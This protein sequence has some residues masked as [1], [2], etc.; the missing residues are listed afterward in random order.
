MYSFLNL[1][2]QQYPDLSIMDLMNLIL[3]ITVG[4]NVLYMCVCMDL[5]G[6]YTAVYMI[7][8]GIP[9]SKDSILFVNTRKRGEKNE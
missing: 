6:I 8:T 7:N 3:L 9:F 5:I 2:S 4:K 1:L